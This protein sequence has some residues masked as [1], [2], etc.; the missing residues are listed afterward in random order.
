MT[1][2]GFAGFSGGGVNM[3]QVS[4]GAVAIA[5]LHMATPGPLLHC[6]WS[7]VICLVPKGGN[8]LT[9]SQGKIQSLQ[10]RETDLVIVVVFRTKTYFHIG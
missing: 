6:C 4:S 3:Q 9:S 1:E 7:T 5:S 8:C 2:R 10:H